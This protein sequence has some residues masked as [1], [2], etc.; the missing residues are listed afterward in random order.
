VI[1]PVRLYF[2]PHVLRRSARGLSDQYATADPFPHV[3]IDD[4]LPEDALDL[5]LDHFPPAESDVWRA[6]DNFS[7]VK[8]ETQGESRLPEPISLLLYQFN[9]A[10]FLR[11]LEHLTGMDSL[12]PDPYFSGGG[13]H[14]IETGG[15][16]GIHADFSRH[17]TL[18]LH[19]RVNVLIYLNRDWPE[20][21]GGH[22]ELWNRDRSRCVQ[23]ILPI[24]NRMVVFSVDDWAFHGHPEP[25][26]CP[27]GVTRKS[28]AL[29]YFTVDRPPG[30][31]MEGKETT[32]FYPRPDEEVPEGTV[33][34][35]NEW[36]GMAEDRIQRRWK[37][38]PARSFAQRWA[39]PA[40]LDSARAVRSRLRERRR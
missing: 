34:S 30:Q 38:P 1:E 3:V 40:L 21:Y 9:S 15:K 33:F 16:L 14:Q 12:L 19:R 10:P 27:A 8:L 5:A 17:N 20:S 35:R 39:P 36:S 28:I 37:K 13:L 18:P 23:R 26:T 24:F 31:V 7:E 4:L 29:Y 6:Y 22:L 25:L 11:F 2:D 32:L